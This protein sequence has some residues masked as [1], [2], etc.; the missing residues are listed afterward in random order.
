M[1]EIWRGERQRATAVRTNSAVALRGKARHGRQEGLEPSLG[2]PRSGCEDCMVLL[3]GQ[4]IAAHVCHTPESMHL[5]RTISKADCICV[6]LAMK[7]WMWRASMVALRTLVF[8]ILVPGMVGGLFPWL[9]AHGAQ[10]PA[11][12]V[13]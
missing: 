1:P 10:G 13:W 5:E 8:T 2:S 9:L 3:C 12:P 11:S 6:S 7:A 4:S